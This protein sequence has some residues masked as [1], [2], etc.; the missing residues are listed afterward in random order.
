[1]ESSATR[2]E[3]DTHGDGGDVGGLE[4]GM[5]L[6]EQAGDAGQHVVAGHAVQHAGGGGLGVHGIGDAH[7]Q[8][9]D[10]QQDLA[11]PVTGGELGS[12]EKKAVS[13]VHLA[14][15]GL[16]DDRPHRSGA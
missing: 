3:K 13:G 12:V 15:V 10:H 11:E 4:A 7:G 9:V 14:H 6:A 5:H 1:M 8:D 16:D 2:M